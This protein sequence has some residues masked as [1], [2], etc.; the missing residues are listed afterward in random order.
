MAVVHLSDAT[1]DGTSLGQSASDKIN[2]YGVLTPIV[3]QTATAAGTDATTTQA[4]ANGIRTA[5]INI[6]LW[7]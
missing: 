4:L 5:L 1:D 7:A 2:F 3:Q 6:G